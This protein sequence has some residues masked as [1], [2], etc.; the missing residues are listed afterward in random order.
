MNSNGVAEWK[1]LPK[2]A[3]RL[4]RSAQSVLWNVHA[5]YPQQHHSVVGDDLPGMYFLGLVSQQGHLH[6]QDML[7]KR[8]YLPPWI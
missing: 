6:Q 4:E 7:Q 2:R 8:E 5:D 1:V 3:A